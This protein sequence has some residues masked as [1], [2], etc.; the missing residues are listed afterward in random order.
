MDTALH[1]FAEQGYSA[2]GMR[3]IADELGIQA[4][5]LYSHFPSKDAVLHAA[6]EPFIDHIQLLL[7]DLPD[8]PV[9]ERA[10]HDWLTRAATMLREHMLQ[11]QLV[12]SDRTLAT[13]SESDRASSRSASSWSGAWCASAYGTRSGRSA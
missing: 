9:S 13:H 8:E 10:R 3:A 7:L 5:S 4:P 6:V 1:L 12:T 11:L 2:V